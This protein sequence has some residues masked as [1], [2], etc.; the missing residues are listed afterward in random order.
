VTK[1]RSVKKR[2][3]I[4]HQQ[5]EQEQREKRKKKDAARH[6]KAAQET[7]AQQLQRRVSHE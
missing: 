6:A 7:G 5:R 4:E 3:A 2:H 1:G